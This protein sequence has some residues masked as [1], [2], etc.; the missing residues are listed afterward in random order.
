MPTFTVLLKYMVTK[1][2]IYLKVQISFYFSEL[3]REE[4]YRNIKKRDICNFK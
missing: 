2:I 4:K 1:H 3:R